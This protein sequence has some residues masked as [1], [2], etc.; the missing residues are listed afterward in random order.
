M[1]TQVNLQDAPIDKLIARKKEIQD[2]SKLTKAE[3]AK[4]PKNANGGLIKGPGTGRSDSIRATL[5]YA[6]GGSIRVSNGEFIVKASS[7]RDYGVAAMNAVNNGTASIGTNSGGTVYNINM[8]ITSNNANPEGVAN[9]VIRRLKV[10]I[11]KNNK[12]NKVNI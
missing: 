2:G 12:S 1:Q 11:N 6:G 7:V 9:E 4:L 5:G 8:P 3:K 10:E